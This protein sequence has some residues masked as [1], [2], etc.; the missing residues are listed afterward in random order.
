MFAR[1]LLEAL[2]GFADPPVPILAVFLRQRR[3][4]VQG[5]CRPRMQGENA[6]SGESLNDFIGSAIEDFDAGRL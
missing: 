1:G 5:L 3:S 4:P 2:P 6:G